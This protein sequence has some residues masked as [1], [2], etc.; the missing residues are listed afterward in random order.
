MRYWMAV[1]LVWVPRGSHG[2][3][4]SVSRGQRGHTLSAS[5]DVKVYSIG[6]DNEPRLLEGSSGDD[7]LREALCSKDVL[8]HLHRCPEGELLP[9]AATPRTDHLY[10]MSDSYRAAVAD[11]SACPL[12]SPF[13]HVGSGNACCVASTDAHVWPNFCASIAE[14][15]KGPDG[16]EWET[17]DEVDLLPLTGVSRHQ[18]TSSTERRQLPQGI[19]RVGFPDVPKNYEKNPTSVV[20]LSVYFVMFAICVSLY[21]YVFTRMSEEASIAQGKRRE[22]AFFSHRK[23][24]DDSDDEEESVDSDSAASLS[25]AHT[26]MA[27]N[28]QNVAD[29]MG[30]VSLSFGLLPAL[31]RGRN[32]NL[33]SPRMSARGPPRS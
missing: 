16:I 3:T 20:L 4:G 8:V 21:M 6:P 11:K 23:F 13:M 19:Y 2:S 27:R 14:L 15:G 30:Q 26:A 22:E 31:P 9:P 10:P 33:S 18:E 5:S 32:S 29:S 28:E 17:H 24:V 7:Q 1:V 25:P 12:P